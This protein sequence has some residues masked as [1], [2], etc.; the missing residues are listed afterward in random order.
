MVRERR[1]SPTGREQTPS[2]R[3][4]VKNLRSVLHVVEMAKRAVRIAHLHSSG[5]HGLSRGDQLDDLNDLVEPIL[6]GHQLACKASSQGRT[7]HRSHFGRWRFLDLLNREHDPWRLFVLGIRLN[8]KL[9]APPDNKIK[10]IP[11]PVTLDLAVERLVRIKPNLHLTRAMAGR[12]ESTKHDL[13]FTHHLCWTTA[14]T[15]RARRH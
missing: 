5:R 12:L 6:L 2:V 14:R 10:Q 1:Q 3:Y 4:Q 13:R 9:V 11:S 15:R 8:C 7:R